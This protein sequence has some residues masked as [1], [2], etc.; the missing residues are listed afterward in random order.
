[1]ALT[2]IMLSGC[3]SANNTDKNTTT[4]PSS[5]ASEKASENADASAE[6]IS[7]AN[8][9][10]DGYTLEQVLILSR[11]NIRSPLSNEGS[12]LASVTT[13]D[14]FD[15]TSGKSELSLRGGV[16]ETEMGQYFRKYLVSKG[17]M[18]E[19][20]EPADNEVRIYANSMQRTIATANYF[21]SAFLPVD[22]IETEYHLEIGEMDPVFHP[23]FTFL[24]EAFKEQAMKEI[25]ALGGDKGIAGIT[26]NLS[27]NYK[28]LEDILNFSNSEY[29]KENS[30]TSF[31]LDAPEIKFEMNEEPYMTGTLDL[32]ASIC[33]ALVLQ[34]Y[35][36]NGSKEASFGKEL[37][38][39]QWKQI[40][41]I[42]DVYEEVIFATHSISVNVANPMLKEI[43]KELNT[44]GR[45]VSYLCGHDSNVLTVLTAL[46]VED[47]NLPGA[48]SKDTPIGCKLVIQKWSNKDG[49]TYATVDMIYQS[50]DQ[51]QKC[52]MLDMENPPMVYSLSFDGLEKNADG[53]YL[54]D[55]LM[56]R[57]DD[58]ISAYD[59]LP[60]D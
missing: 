29:A 23:K 55:D 57:F 59:N 15:W 26:E 34:Y 53:Y 19:N 58:E 28:L 24:S 27:E 42:S 35:E 3:S 45:K 37:T 8:R 5:A 51:L 25:A 31:G 4:E 47:Y 18:T 50:V 38:F 43:R 6:Q 30:I 13:N 32:T 1:M 17:L 60:K 46:G 22:D 52:T 2:I 16:L 7:T 11:H 48:I 21:K 44:D 20:W 39:D 9:N 49:K 12:T 54:Y 40:A 36:E 14:W 10:E 41:R 33:D 56:K